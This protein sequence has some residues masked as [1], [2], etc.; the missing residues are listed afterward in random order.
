MSLIFQALAD[1]P[2]REKCLALIGTAV[3]AINLSHVSTFLG[4]VVAL[5]T[6]AMLVPRAALNWR[7]LKQ[8]SEDR[9]ACR[10]SSEKKDRKKS[11]E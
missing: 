1:S 10:R 5:C 2:N 4:I 6:I 7:E 9:R 8:D 11:Q 3:A